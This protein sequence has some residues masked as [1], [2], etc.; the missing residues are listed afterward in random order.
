[1]TTNRREV[2]PGRPRGADEPT[3]TVAVRLPKSL[4]SRIDTLAEHS[5]RSRANY[6]A[7]IIRRAVEGDPT[8]HTST[9]SPQQRAITE[10]FS[11][12]ANDLAFRAWVD[13]KSNTLYF[14][15]SLAGKRRRIA[16]YDVATNDMGTLERQQL[17]DAIEKL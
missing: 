14:D 3:E 4:I 13:H 7:L 17:N 8:M 9:F 15:A 11:D 1:M 16:F 2:R 5:G 6:L 12:H 10:A